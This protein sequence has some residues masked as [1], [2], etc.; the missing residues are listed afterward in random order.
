MKQFII[1]FVNTLLKP[2]VIIYDDKQD[3]YSTCCG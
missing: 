3:L 2:D 1:T